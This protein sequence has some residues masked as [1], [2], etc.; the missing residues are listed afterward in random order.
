MAREA[1]GLLGLTLV[2]APVVVYTHATPFPDLA[3]LPPC[4]GAALLIHSG[5]TD[6]CS[7]GPTVTARF[8]AFAP[9]VWIG[10]ISYSLYLCHWPMIVFY[11]LGIHSVPGV[12]EKLALF[13]V[14]IVLAWFSWRVVERPFRL[15]A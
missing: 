12:D 2:V 7:A 1:A 15:R 10:L 9:F 5:R 14:M 4:L 6:A 8:L 3:A 11:R 13:A